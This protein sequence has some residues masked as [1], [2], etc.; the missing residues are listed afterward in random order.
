[1]RSSS[2]L[3]VS[4]VSLLIL[5]LG[6]QTV[7]ADTQ[8]PVE[9]SPA[10]VTPNTAVTITTTVTMHIGSV[11]AI[12]VVVQTP[13]GQVWALTH[14]VILNYGDGGGDTTVSC[15]I[16]FGA[17]GTDSNNASSSNQLAVQGCSGSNSGSWEQVTGVTFSQFES[18]CPSFPSFTAGTAG[19]GSTNSS[20][21][22]QVLSCVGERDT[23]NNPQL[24]TFDVESATSAVPQ[25][26]VSGFGIFMLVAL[27]LP[28][29][30]ILA[31]ARKPTVPA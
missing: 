28:V 15:S 5:M 23:A 17:P 25:F 24:T 11:D 2:V 6:V 4:V 3:L 21:E 8:R 10:T 27:L 29:L 9:A 19:V 18:D 20:G 30:V 22:Y 31:R 7:M 26:P 14:L 16:P 1:M 13:T 12:E